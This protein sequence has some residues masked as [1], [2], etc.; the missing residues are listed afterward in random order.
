MLTIIKDVATILGGA[1]SAIIGF[2]FGNKAATDS[3][4]EKPSPSHRKK[5]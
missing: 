5:Q 3:V 1:V 2:Y 4:A